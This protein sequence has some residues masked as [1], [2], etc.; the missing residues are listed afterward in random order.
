MKKNALLYFCVVFISVVAAAQPTNEFITYS[1]ANTPAFS[2]NNFKAIWVGKG[3]RIWA[4]TQY[5]GLYWFDTA[6]KAWTKS[7]QLGNVF[8]NHIQRDKNGGIWIAQSGSSGLVGG[9]SNTAGGINYFPDTT[10]AGM[11]HFNTSNFISSRNVRSLYL[12][13]IHAAPADFRRVWAAQ[14]TF[15]TSGNTAAGG[16][17][18][19][20]NIT[21]NNFQ[22]IIRGLQVFPNTNFVSTGTPSCYT[23]DG[24]K[25]EVW[26]GAE[27]NYTTSSG[28]SSQILRYE[29]VTGAL[30]GG[31]DQNGA[32]DNTRM[33]YNDQK[34]NYTDTSTKGILPPTFRTTAIHF[35]AEGRQWV[36]FR[37]GAV[38]VKQAGMWKAVNMPSVFVPGSIINFNAITSDEFGYV[39]FGTNAGLVVF[40]GGG[41]VD[42]PSNYKKLT[43][44]E[45][46][47]SNTITGVCYDKSRGVML[48]TSDAGVT[49][50]KLK[51]KI[52][53]TMQWDY[54]FP[55]RKNNPIG[56]AADGVARIYLKVKKANDTLPEI[57]EVNMKLNGWVANEANIRGKLKKATTI[58]KYSEEASTG[59]VTELAIS[60]ADLKPGQAGEYWFWY[61]APDDF[62]ND[63]LSNFSTLTDRYDSVRVIVT[64]VTNRKDTVNFPIRVVRPPLILQ[65]GYNGAPYVWDDF[66]Y[67]GINFKTSHHFK[68]VNTPAM[69]PA[70]TAKK[71]AIQML[72]ADNALFG[73]DKLNTLAGNIEVLRSMRFA[74]NQVDFVCHSMGGM[75]IR[76]A[77]GWYEKKFFAGE[78]Y[79]Y[80]NYQKGFT[81][82]IITINT[83]HNGSTIP[84]LGFILL[85]NG[86]LPNFLHAFLFRLYKHNVFGL[87]YGSLGN[88]IQPIDENNDIFSRMSLTDATTNLQTT[89]ANGGV[90][91]PLTKNVKNHIIAG[92]IDGLITVLP[93]GFKV[94]NLSF[95]AIDEGLSA[96]YGILLE[97]QYA[98]LRDPIDG[99]PVLAQEFKDKVLSQPHDV[100]I[101]TWFDA[102]SKSKGYPDFFGNSDMI[103]PLESEL[104]RQSQ[105]LPNVTVFKNTAPNKV[106]AEHSS[107]IRKRPDVGKFVF[108]LLNTK[109]SSPLFGDTISANRNQDY[110]EKPILNR[111]IGKQGG[112][113]LATFYDTSKIRID[114]PQ[115]GSTVNNDS[116][117]SIKFRVKDTA[118]L[119]YVS[120][121]YQ[122][123]DSLTVIKTKAQQTFSVKVHPSIIGNNDITAVAVYDKPGGGL[124][125]HLDTLSITAVHAGTLQDFRVN[126]QP[127]NIIGG[128]PYYPSLQV[129]YNN[130]WITLPNDAAG[131]NVNV[132]DA[133]IVTVNNSN[134]SLTG[135]SEGAT[136]A[137]YSYGEFVDTVAVISVMPLSTNCINKTV[138]GGSYKNPAIWSKGTVPG[139]CDSVVI[140]TGHT[141]SADTS[142][143]NRSLRINAGAALI[144]NSAADTLQFGTA[145]EGESIIDNYGTLNITTG[146]IKIQ[147]RVR[148][149]ANSNFT[150]SGGTV[151]I[152]GNTGLKETSTPNNLS[153]FE[154][155][156][157]MAAFNFSGGL[158]EITDPPYSATSQAINCSYNFGDNSTLILGANTSTTASKN[159]DGFGGNLFPNKIGKLI[160]NAG[161]KTGNRQFI[162]K[163]A[164]NVKG[165]M[166]VRT[167]SG[168][169][170][171]API[172]VNQ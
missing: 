94:S 99:D 97:M 125:Y 44:A 17:V 114:F 63:S 137:N 31:Y 34:K 140:S 79:T 42:N 58:N 115:R 59:T 103:V 1:T 22:K 122:F 144:V 18:R 54:S 118:N 135:I 66:S 167:G 4:G 23:V 111:P 30:L 10:D 104:V 39:Y 102:Y 89:E 170:L 61:V 38:V 129:K 117:L 120:I 161:T 86:K 60:N 107:I 98:A 119:A 27:T 56:V 101:F 57:K 100:R 25:N 123:S 172:T 116:T 93:G 73:A 7:A 127:V 95:K 8:I 126:E 142:I 20:Q 145:D 141:V 62:S 148:L 153:L 165:N 139:I 133:N 171:Q 109:I 138:A 131:L 32:F 78:G 87:K 52:D 91:L 49:F 14:A 90:K 5:Q 15:T 158:L 169:I 113:I 43:T 92:D 130:T 162:N 37:S 156:P 12:D 155:A 150:M 71:A 3:N 166:E 149:N 134:H 132:E 75:Y 85:S 9:A 136:Q 88:S 48:I 6:R 69:D 128:M 13:T 157:G 67:S 106:D 84:D 163:K 80:K 112:S 24:N 11:Q 26:V 35:D 96:F 53:V 105:S 70:G 36:G 65:H 110:T 16:I 21:S 121:H 147:G 45:G 82:K 41:A 152:D 40:D 159:T 164:L 74:S 28:S 51:Y 143:V 151:K 46:L 55:E 29:A 33:Y 124:D 81:H 76:A 72:G 146:N 77:I 47:P 19:Q 68:Y 50:W 83:P 108:N 64:Y 160:I 2:G 168:V 154:A